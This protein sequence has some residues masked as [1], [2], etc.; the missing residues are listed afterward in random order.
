M[1]DFAA[2]TARRARWVEKENRYQAWSTGETLAVALVLCDRDMLEY[3]GY[4]DQEAT[5]RV[6]GGMISP[7]Q[8]FSAWLKTIRET[9]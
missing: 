2:A 5:Q 8:D 7:P 6:C 1:D 9:L 3:M 4:T